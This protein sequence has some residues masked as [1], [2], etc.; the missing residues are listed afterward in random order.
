MIGIYQD[1]FM[2]LLKENLGD[3]IKIYSN[4]IVVRC[5]YCEYDKNKDHYHMNIYL[6]FPFFRCY[7]AGCNKRGHISK[8][9]NK[10]NGLNDLNNYIDPEKVKKHDIKNFSYNVKNKNFI[11][12]DLN[13]DRFVLKSMYM[14]KRI[15]FSD[16]Q[17]KNINGMIFDVEKFIDINKIQ[18]SNK[19]NKMKEFL[20]NNFIGF[21]SEHHTLLT[22]RNISDKSEIRYLKIK[23]EDGNNKFSDY[24]KINGNKY[25]SNS[26]VLGEGVF[27]ILLENIYNSIEIKNDVKLYA[28]CLNTD[29]YSLIKSLVFNEQ[30]YNPEIHILSDNGID[31]NYYRELKKKTGFLFSKLV[32]YY[33][34]SGKDFADVPVNFEKFII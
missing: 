15:R 31:I 16:V 7:Y 29:Y 27:D 33:N 9:I 10:L 23:L 19:M 18:L 3:P 5:P 28:A 14:K 34:K 2:D 22:L 1:S 30:I 12:P 25:N 8:L 26:F 21:I 32:I 13:E 6:E 11:L 20:F 17:L 24:Y 4:Y